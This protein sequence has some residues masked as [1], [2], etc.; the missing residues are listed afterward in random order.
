MGMLLQGY[1]TNLGKYVESELIGRW[2]EFP[3]SEDDLEDVLEEIGVGEEYGEFFFTDW[4]SRIPVL[5]SELGE[6]PSIS[7]VNSLVEKIAKDEEKAAAIIEAFCLSDFM[8]KDMDD[9][10]LWSCSPQDDEDLGRVVAEAV[11]FDIP[12]HLEYYF[13]YEKYGCNF[14]FNA[15]GDWCE[16]GYIEYLG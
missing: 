7:E 2:I 4:N 11:C 8:E 16:A 9:Y 14:R 15:N 1:I 3:I 10:I 6:Y 5:S 12:Q 13:D